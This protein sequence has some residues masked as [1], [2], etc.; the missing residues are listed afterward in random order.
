[1]KKIYA[2]V[3]LLL[4]M[5]MAAGCTQ[6]NTV[7]AIKSRG[8]LVVATNAEFP[9]FEYMDG[10]NFVG[11]DMEIAQAIADKLGVKLKIDNMAFDSVLVAV[12]TGKD[13][14][15]IAAL[16]S[17]TE[18][19]KSMDFSDTYFTSSVVMI[20]AKDNT[21]LKTV[22]DLKGKKIGVQLGTVADTMIATP[23]EGAEVVRMNK[24]ADSVQ[25]LINGKLDAVLLDSSPAKVFADQNADKVTLIDTPLS[26][27][28]YAISAKKGNKELLQ[29]VNDVIKEL[30]DSGK[31]EQILEKYKVKLQ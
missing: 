5:T 30:K 29:V 18:R 4:V 10:N 23:I 8:E 11:V 27:D 9:P 21:T 19:Q 2:V 17:D 28:Q 15:G 16:S 20:V 14:L 12:P 25:D 31:Y 1:M 7:A 13:D 3:A 24:D 26:N 22:D 6:S